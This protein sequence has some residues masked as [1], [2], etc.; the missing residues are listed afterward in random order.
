M[1]LFHDVALKWNFS[2][3]GFPNVSVNP[4]VRLTTWHSV[5]KPVIVHVVHDDILNHEVN[6]MFRG[7]SEANI[8]IYVGLRTKPQIC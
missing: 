1:Q 4:L 5:K 6:V 3:V 8:F 2:L 7:C